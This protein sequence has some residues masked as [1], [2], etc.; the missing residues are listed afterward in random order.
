MSHDIF[1]SYSSKDRSVAD[2]VVQSLEAAGV[3]CWYAP[4]DIHPGR[5]W[6]VAI[7]EAIEESRIFVVIFSGNANR[8]Q[9]V[10]DE[11]NLA[12]SCELVILPFRIE[13]LDPSGAMLLHLSSRHWLDAYAPSWERHLD[14]L[15]ETAKAFLAG[16]E[17]RSVPSA[18]MTN[19]GRAWIGKLA[20]GLGA[21]FT[22]AA[23]ILVFGMDTLFP[24]GGFAWL[25]WS[26]SAVDPSAA[27]AASYTEASMETPDAPESVSGADSTDT[28]AV[29]G[30][31][32]P[33]S[34]V[35]PF[36]WM[37]VP[38][39]DESFNEVSSMAQAV[40]SAFHDSN[41]GLWMK[42]VP[43]P[44]MASAA[45]ALCDGAVQIALLDLV[46]YL[47]A[48]ERGCA[49][50]RL[51][52]SAYSDINYGGMLFVNSESG[53]TSIDGLAGRTLCIPDYTSVS[54]WLLPS[55][56]IQADA[57]DPMA[58]F[59]EI[60]ETGTHDQAVEEVYY[61][62]CDAGTAYYDVRENMDLPDVMDR[63]TVLRT[64]VDIPN[65]NVSFSSD[66]GPDQVDQLVRFFLEVANAGEGEDL[67]I[68]A[69]YR[70]SPEVGSLVEINDY[71]YNAIRRLFEEAGEDPAEYIIQN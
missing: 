42:A 40:S 12:I 27:A 18:G 34:E 25:P 28:A 45:D 63:I 51:I 60:R 33:G 9:R 31:D 14:R 71:Y 19:P 38:P 65:I 7:T 55:L 41:P 54:G 6:G 10:L 24:G 46:S 13:N 48:S 17:I 4:R 53:I 21:A 3:R 26:S 37:Y 49:E 30:G 50:A 66:L 61:R 8:S 2:A 47:S 39:V 67:N 43:A 20:Y 23:L 68:I 29:E 58:F 5:D 52:W 16:E 15:V 69:G 64:T 70:N 57:G 32:S 22:L 1:I 11:L 62:R 56:E 35:N 44:D 36:T 59:G